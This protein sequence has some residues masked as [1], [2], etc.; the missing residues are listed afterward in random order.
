MAFEQNSTEDQR[1]AFAETLS[2]AIDMAGIGSVA[3]LLRQLEARGIT[4]TDSGVRRWLNGAGEPQR[5]VV[6]ELEQL[7]GLAPGVLSHHLGWAPVETSGREVAGVSIEDAV[8]ADRTLKA[9]DKAIIVDLI[10]ALR[11]R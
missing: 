11:D 2:L 6:L 8:V 3:E 10:N 9:S 4:M 5:P 7:C 1:R